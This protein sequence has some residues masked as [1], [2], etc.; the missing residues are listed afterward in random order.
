MS[1]WD[2]GMPLRAVLTL[3]ALV[4]ALALSACG[5][6]DD[7]A[8]AGAPSADR[9]QAPDGGN[10]N[11]SDGGDGG[12]T[13]GS[14]GGNA[15]AGDTEPINLEQARLTPAERQLLREKAPTPRP[16]REVFD[17]GSDK[18]KTTLLGIY[19]QMQHDF[20]RARFL[21]FCKHFTSSLRALPD[22]QSSGSEQRFKECAGIVSRIAQRLAQGKLDWR[23]SRIQ[24]IRTYN[25]PGTEPYG[26]VTVIAGFRQVRL[27]FVK[28]DGR[29]RPDFRVPGD[30]QAL[31][32][33]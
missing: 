10:A 12:A 2:H 31:S 22:L 14:G 21:S 20:Y 33:S 11:A 27:S 19:R 7:G 16:Y 28:E 4:A 23:P 17:R 25:D 15:S 3:A 24:W 18:Q 9:A 8:D 29:W 30:L 26:G 1:F 5:D 6:D 32:A 13:G